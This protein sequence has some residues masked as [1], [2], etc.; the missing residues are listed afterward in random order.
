MYV[1]FVLLHFF[2]NMLSVLIALNMYLSLPWGSGDHLTNAN[3][4]Q[5]P[6]RNYL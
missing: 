2:I 4:W 1:H 6:E 5:D 3:N